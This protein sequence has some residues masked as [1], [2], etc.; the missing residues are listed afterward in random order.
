MNTTTQRTIGLIIM[1]IGLIIGIYAIIVSFGA[2]Y[3]MSILIFLIG[4]I[5]ND[6]GIYKLLRIYESRY[7]HINE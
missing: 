3:D 4:I 7:G 5:I 1:S 6:L 2:L